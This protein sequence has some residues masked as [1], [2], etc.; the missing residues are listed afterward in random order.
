M[1]CQCLGCH[2]LAQEAC[3]VLVLDRSQPI[4]EEIINQAK[5]V[6]I[7]RRDTHIDSLMDKFNEPRVSP[8]IDA[9][10]SGGDESQDFSD[11]DVQYCKDL[12]L[13]SATAPTLE[14]AN[15]IYKQI[16]PAVLRFEVSG[17]DYS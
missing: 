9:I 2:A 1:A 5:D 16:I 14:I 4:T 8:I 7:F 13:L 11:D 17:N 15:P 6:L 10:M 12:G 3:F